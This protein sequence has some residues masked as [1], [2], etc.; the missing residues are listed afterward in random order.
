MALFKS[1]EDRRIERNIA[2]R[3]T[4]GLFA[5][6]IGKLKTAEDGYIASAREA[7]RKGASGQEA[8]ARKALKATMVQRR[9]M[10][11]QMLTLKIASQMKDQAEMHGQFANALSAVSKTIGEMFAAVDLTATQKKFELAMGK[12][13]SME[14]RVDLF[15]ETSDETMFAESPAGEPGELVSEDELDRLIDTEAAAGE[16]GMDD[17]IAAKLAEVQNELGKNTVKE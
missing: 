6:Q 4:L 13:Q 17:A 9:R 1:K 8:L 10:D 11:Q 14:E 7:R 15:L 12:A 5:R 2:I 16:A 3:K